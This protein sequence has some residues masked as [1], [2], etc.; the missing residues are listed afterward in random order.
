MNLEA[1]Y[2]DELVALRQGARVEKNWQLADE[3]RDYLDSQHSFVFDT[4]DGQ[5]VYHRAE[6]TRSELVVQLKDQARSEKRFDSW[7]YSL[8]AA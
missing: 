7:L 4:K 5:V 2:I 3:I 6:G 1:L 8:K